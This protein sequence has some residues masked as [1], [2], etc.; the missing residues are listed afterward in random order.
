MDLKC[1]LCDERRIIG[2]GSEAHI[3]TIAPHLDVVEVS[4]DSRAGDRR[5]LALPREIDA[6]VPIKMDKPYWYDRLIDSAQERAQPV[7]LPLRNEL[8]TI[9]QNAPVARTQ[10]PR[11]IL[12]R[13]MPA[14]RVRS[15]P[16][17]AVHLDLG[18]DLRNGLEGTVGA[19]SFVNDDFVC[20]RQMVS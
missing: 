17:K 19:E 5:N 18:I 11:L 3:R 8:V 16:F 1:L 6:V 12:E 4:M 13:A 20:E 14:I 7:K 15:I 9:E 10:T 2:L